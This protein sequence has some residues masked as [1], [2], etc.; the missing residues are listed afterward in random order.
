MILD[1]GVNIESSND[2][3]ES[4]YYE[5]YEKFLDNSWSFY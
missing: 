2:D 1:Y 3:N 4:L 5:S